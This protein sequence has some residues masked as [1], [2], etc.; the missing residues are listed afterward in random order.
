[1]REQHKVTINNNEYLIT[2][3]GARKGIRVG[4]KV[5]KVMLPAIGKMYGE[6]EEVSFGD[7]LETVA[8]NL[9]ELDDQT[10]MELI[11]ETTVN[12]M[13]IDFDDHFSGN[14]GTLF[15]LLWEIIQ[16]NFSDIFSVVPGGTEVTE[17]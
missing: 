1:M 9:D 4:K 2:Q 15:Y 3:F 13:T 5:A 6:S 11:S 12:K 10:I 16:Y 14:Y 8:D 7:M 17:E